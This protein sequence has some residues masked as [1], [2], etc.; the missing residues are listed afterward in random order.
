MNS[1]IPWVTDV[2]WLFKVEGVAGSGATFA[3][4]FAGSRQDDVDFEP[5]RI[6]KSHPQGVN[7][8]FSKLPV[9]CFLALRREC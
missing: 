8:G 1:S 3:P 6:R 9:T 7:Q 4:R 2:S 5:C